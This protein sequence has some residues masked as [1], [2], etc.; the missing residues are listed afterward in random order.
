MK[1]TLA[2]QVEKQ[3]EEI[4]VPIKFPDKWKELALPFA[5]TPSAVVRLQGE[6]GTG[7]TALANLLARKAKG[8]KV[9]ID[10][11]TIAN[12]NYGETEHKTIETFR[13]ATETK[14]TTL[15]FEECDALFWDRSMVTAENIGV[16]GIVNTLLTE[17]DRFKARDIPSLLIFTTNHPKLLD[18]ALESR[19]T[20]V[21]KLEVPKGLMAQK[22][23]KSKLPKGFVIS[24]TQLEN[25]AE[26]GFTPRKM[27]NTI[28][29]ICRT[30][31]IQNRQ[32][33]FADFNDNYFC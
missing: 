24:Q 26:W 25:M 33:E 8:P 12:C 14:A 6:P 11:S 29:Q 31:L 28:V 27:E 3:I 19:F 21:I 7:K 9:H 15:I 30:A 2:P 13:I 4:L 23:W 16:L 10:F 20:D 22:M 5:P 17:I 18:P 32:P 1:L